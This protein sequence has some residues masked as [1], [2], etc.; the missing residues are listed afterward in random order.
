MR[1]AFDLPH[2]EGLTAGRRQLLQGPFQPRQLLPAVEPLVLQRRFAPDGFCGGVQRHDL[3]AATV[4][5]QVRAKIQGGPEQKCARLDD[6]AAAIA[7]EH[8]RIGLLGD[9]GGVM[10]IA[11][12][13]RKEPQQLRVVL[14][15]PGLP[16]RRPTKAQMRNP[17]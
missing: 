17:A 14:L 8:A 15:H 11:E 1:H 9:I 2:Q 6:G 4:A 13:S 10:R 5:I 16:P 7:I 3:A 12:F